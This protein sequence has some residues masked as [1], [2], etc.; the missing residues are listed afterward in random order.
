M[1]ADHHDFRSTLRA[2]IVRLQSFKGIHAVGL[3][4]LCIV[5]FGIIYRYFIFGSR[6]YLYGN[7]GSDT[8]RHL[9][10]MIMLSTIDPLWKDHLYAMDH[11]KEGIGMRGYGQKDPLIE[12]KR[13]EVRR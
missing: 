6:Y 11:L 12:Y 3:L 13:E 8:M 1:S 4:L 10:K 2:I 5:I 7:I 9:E